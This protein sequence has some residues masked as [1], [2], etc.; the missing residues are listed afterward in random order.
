MFLSYLYALL[1]VGTTL[2]KGVD[3]SLDKGK[4]VCNESLL[5]ES[6]R[7]CTKVMTDRYDE[8]ELGTV[9]YSSAEPC[10][11]R[12]RPGLIRTVTVER[13]VMRDMFYRD[14]CDKLWNRLQR[15][16][17]CDLSDDARVCIGIPQIDWGGCACAL[18]SCTDGP[19][20]IAIGRNRWED[21]R[22][23]EKAGKEIGW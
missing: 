1:A 21:C 19:L 2:C 15:P 20:Q 5:L 6:P 4:F 22:R 18:L 17:C 14:P 11:D 3:L 16:A 13:F 23:D 9:E 10:C 12:P 8:C 7:C